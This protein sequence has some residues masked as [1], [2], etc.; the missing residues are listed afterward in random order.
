MKNQYT[1]IR[2]GAEI[3]KEKMTIANTVEP[4]PK[5][6]A[7]RTCICQYD[8]DGNLVVR[9]YGP[10]LTEYQAAH[11]RHECHW[12]CPICYEEAMAN[13]CYKHEDTC[14]SI[15]P[16]RCGPDCHGFVSINNKEN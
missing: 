16:G 8:A 6:A 5:D 2:H 10:T 15:P 4:T 7:Q 12:A 9:T 11:D 13:T 3:L 14:S 1:G